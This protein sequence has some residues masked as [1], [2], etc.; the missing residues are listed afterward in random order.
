LVVLTY[1][2][3]RE[4]HPLI[5]DVNSKGHPDPRF[6]GVTTQQPVKLVTN[7]RSEMDVLEMYTKGELRWE[8]TGKVCG[9]CVNYYHDYNLKATEGR[10][11]ARGFMK[12]T[13][14]TPANERKSWTK[15]GVTFKPWP[16]CPYFVQ[17]DRL[18][19]R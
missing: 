17:R 9:E 8:N 18:S 6:R 2:E 10:C 5:V 1:K 19:R 14:D 11:K 3:L 12:V 16:S 13:E 4:H 15:D 7:T